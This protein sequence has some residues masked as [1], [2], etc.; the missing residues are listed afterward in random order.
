MMLRRAHSLSY[1]KVTTREFSRQKHDCISEE[2]AHRTYVV[3]TIETPFECPFVGHSSP[4]FRCKLR[5]FFIQI[6]K[7]ILWAHLNFMFVK[8]LSTFLEWFN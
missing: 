7:T 3:P 1:T 5:R 8:R 6:S 4:A 2:E